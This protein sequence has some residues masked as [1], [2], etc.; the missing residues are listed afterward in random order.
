M[1][2]GSPAL[3]SLG[4]NGWAPTESPLRETT[5]RAMAKKGVRE[6]VKLSG[7]ADGGGSVLREKTEYNVTLTSRIVCERVPSSQLRH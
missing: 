5:S 6:V 3:P 4:I 2:A 7:S 1:D